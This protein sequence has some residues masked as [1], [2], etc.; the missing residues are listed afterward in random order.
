MKVVGLVRLFAS[1][2]VSACLYGQVSILPVK[3]LKAGMRGSG[4]TV[5]TGS[6]IESFD[7]EILG[8]LENA[9]PKQSIILA[10]LSGGPLERT[11]VLQGMS[12]SP[13]YID[14]KLVGA[15][16]MA[17]PFTKEPIAGIRPIGEMLA[18]SA[19]PPRPPQARAKLNDK[20][21][22]AHFPKP[23]P[24]GA[25]E[26]KLIDLATPISFSGF[27]RGAIEHFSPQLRM[28][29]L[30]PRQGISSGRTPEADKPVPPQPGSMISVQLVNGDMSMG[31]DGT[32]THVDRNRIWAFGH[33]FLSVGAT[34][35]PFTNSSVITLLPNLSTSFKIS[36]SG[37]MV[38]AITADHNAVITGELGKRAR[39][40]PVTIAV[41]GA[42][43]NSQYRMEM[44]QDRL[45]SPL[46]LQM[47]TYSV[48]DVTERTL[49]SSSIRL[50][51]TVRF[52]GISEP[53]RIENMYSGDFNVPLV[54]SLG[55]SLPV[56]YALQNTVDLLRLQ[57][58]DLTIDAFPEK[59]QVSIEQVW[60]S[61]RDVRPGEPLDISVLM[62][63][64]GGVEITR[65]LRYD[66]PIG[67]PV[68]QLSIT[69]A[70]GA[71]TNAT[72]QRVYQLSQPR[73][74]TQV[75]SFLNSLRGSTKGYMRVWRAEPAYTL[76]GQDL[77]D[78]PPSVGMI[79]ARTPSAN[80]LLGKSSTVAE[81]EFSAGD[82]VISGSK[83]IQVDVKE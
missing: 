33:R 22:V 32:V 76:D 69:V 27:T 36:A 37:A 82:V 52:E 68:G 31:A 24:V 56:A 41:N 72:D 77:P 75:V 64:E 18:V 63:G 30:E 54:A 34:E 28:L 79:L 3:D 62:V 4:R 46:L 1:L 71:T 7:V 55:T 35:L 61:K 15:V 78:P 73:P 81:L 10:R 66:V 6:A 83:T 47:L 38:G 65:K 23:E 57:S 20:S 44:V 26:T 19:A 14:G 74:A 9:G 70:D 42:E 40:A 45:L 5:F 39:M 8:V 58:V 2:V 25:F 49:G 51:G 53:V 48:L 16:A 80:P 50:R 17:F 12:G 43:R 67:A 11:G 59:K 21:L 60:S 29:G 13:V